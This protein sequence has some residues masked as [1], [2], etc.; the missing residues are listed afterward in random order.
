MII[1]ADN[2]SAIVFAKDPKFHAWTK[3]IALQHHFIWEKI[4]DGNIELEY[5]QT[6][7]QIADG[8]TKALPKDAFYAFRDVLGLERY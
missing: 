8:F 6:S 2:Q 4:V 7:W 5:I 1:Y 3:H